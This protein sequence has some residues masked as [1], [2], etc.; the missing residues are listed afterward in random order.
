MKKELFFELLDNHQIYHH[1]SITTKRFKYEQI[2]PVINDL[3]N[4]ERFNVEN[5]GTSFKGRNIYLIRWGI[6]KKR[7][8]LWSQMHGDESTATRALLDIWNF[9]K[10]D[11]HFNDV[12]DKL[13]QSISLYFIPILNPDGANIF[14]RRTVQGIDMNRD[15]VSLQTPEANVLKNMR[16]R[17]EPEYGINLHDQSIYYSAG[18]S[19]F[20]ATIS[21]LAPAHNASKDINELRGNAM[22]LI[23]YLSELLQKVIPGQ[24]ARYDDTFNNRAFGDNM[25][26]WGTSTILIE[27]GGYPNDP[28]KEYIRKL[29][30]AVILAAVFE[31]SGGAIQANQE[32]AYL[33]IP[34]NVKEKFF[35]LLIRNATREISGKRFKVDIGIIREEVDYN[36]FRNYYF[37]SKIQ[38]IGDLSQF[39]GF[40][41]FDAK[42][43]IIVPGKNYS[44]IIR[45]EDELEALDFSELLKAGFTTIK[46]SNHKD[47]DKFTLKPINIINEKDERAPDIGLEQPADILILKGEEVVQTIVNGF[48]VNTSQ[49][50][51]G[52]KNAL[53]YPLI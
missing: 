41:E 4:T 21:F 48:L 7:I 53:V 47:S 33:R 3:S 43:M 13:F 20:P 31:I 15:A 35:N 49:E 34:L 38:D 44:E 2:L 24:V 9:L 8:L 5:V 18:E 37:K 32:Q 45:S 25:Q 6:G 36:D 11:D 26:I 39:H 19:S 10:S 40:E 50:N 52:V 12:R 22:S 23:V 28:E 29:N 42:E 30:F 14:Q 17:L 16:D 27:S 46:M 51:L 1:S